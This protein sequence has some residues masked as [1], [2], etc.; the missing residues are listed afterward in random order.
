[1]LSENAIGDGGVAAIGETVGSHATLETLMLSRC[2]I[3]AAGAKA[4]AAGLAANPGALRVCVLWRNDALDDRSEKLLRDAVS[5]R[6]GFE[7]VLPSRPF[8]A[9]RPGK[10]VVLTGATG[11]IG[12]AI[13][14]GVMEANFITPTVSHLV[15]VVKEEHGGEELARPLRGAALQVDVVVAD[16]SRMASVAAAAARIRDAHRRVDVLIN[17]AAVAPPRREEVEG[18]ELQFATNV[19]AYFVLM[20][21][22]LPAMTRGGRVVLVASQLTNELDLGD[23]Q[24]RRGAAA[25]SHVVR[26][27]KTKTAVRM[28]AAEAAAPGRAFAAQ[29]VAVVACHPG[30]VTSTLLRNLGFERGFDTA[31]VAAQTPLRLALGPEVASGT[32]HAN[33]KAVKCKFAD[34]HGARAAL[35]EACE[36][37]AAERLGRC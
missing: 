32:F 19:L 16:L 24:S 10:V 29:G 33:K 26:Y 9:S 30:I 18:L 15:L 35:W 36:A 31:A 13:A 37:L 2:A 22:L 7:L 14:R 4:L 23:L 20:R 11:A 3:G 6:D 8:T 1:M 34:E 21:S 5:A 25:E 12:A 27:A 28:L 17:C